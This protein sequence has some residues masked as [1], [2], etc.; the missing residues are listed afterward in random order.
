MIPVHAELKDSIEALRDVK[1]L[2]QEFPTIIKAAKRN[3]QAKSRGEKIM[4]GLNTLLGNF[5]F[6]SENED[7]ATSVIS[8]YTDADLHLSFSSTSAGLP[9]WPF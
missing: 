1:L 3:K 2:S 7:G 4:I 8:K 6:L 5:K 9:Y